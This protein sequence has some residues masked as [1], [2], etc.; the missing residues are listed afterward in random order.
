MKF[1]RKRR[2]RRANTPDWV[3][4]LIEAADIII[5]GLRYMVK[6]IFHL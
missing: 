1:S 6:S 3:T 4:F 5:I 2:E